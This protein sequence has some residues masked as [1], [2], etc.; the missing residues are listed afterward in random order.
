MADDLLPA[1]D[2]AGDR[3]RVPVVVDV[4]SADFGMVNALLNVFGIQRTGWFVSQEWVLPAFIIM[5]LWAAGGGMILYLAALQQ[6]PTVAVRSGRARRRQRAGGSLRHVSLP[7]TSP[8]I[9]FTFMTGLIGRSRSS[10][11]GTSSPTVAPTTPRCST[12]STCTNRL[13]G[14]PDGLRIGARLGAAPHH[15]GLTFIVLWMARRSVH[16]EFGGSVDGHDRSPMPSIGPAGVRTGAS[17]PH[18]AAAGSGA[19]S[20]LHHLWWSEP[21][22]SPS[23][24]IG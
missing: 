3:R 21:S 9:L 22:S 14:L 20:D 16:Y 13:A 8:M 17:R 7:M 18:G 2:H 19:R 12:S 10:R 6:V 11:P 5:T 4:Q 24:S 15:V 1:L 23:R